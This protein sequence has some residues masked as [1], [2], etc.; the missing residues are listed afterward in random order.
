MQEENDLMMLQKAAE[1][2]GKRLS[3]EYMLKRLLKDQTKII[4]IHK[5]PEVRKNFIKF[6]ST[7]IK[8]YKDSKIP[9]YE[10]RLDLCRTLNDSSLKN[11][12]FNFGDIIIYNNK[13]IYR[14]YRWIDLN[15]FEEESHLN[16]SVIS[17]WKTYGKTMREHEVEDVYGFE[18]EFTD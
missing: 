7:F 17:F 1:A 10:T 12:I 4:V 5:D 8:K 18:F 15:K 16:F 11:E 13:D 14:E 9:E 3:M 6:L 2:N